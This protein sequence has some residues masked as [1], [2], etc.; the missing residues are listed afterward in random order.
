MSITAH[1]IG[2]TEEAPEYYLMLLDLE[3][4][5]TK[6]SL[7]NSLAVAV[8]TSDSGRHSE[9]R[10]MLS[11]S[12]LENIEDRSTIISASQ[13]KPV[14]GECPICF[15]D[16]R[17]SQERTSCHLCG[18]DV[19]VACFESWEAT[20]RASKDVVCCIYC[21]APWMSDEHGATH[22]GGEAV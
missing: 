14:D 9:L 13:R 19:H 15:N 18:N 4:I 10:Q 21:K 20:I 11:A 7:A 22:L 2:G 3:V 16:F 5:S 17:A 8:R 12:S 6:R 1:N